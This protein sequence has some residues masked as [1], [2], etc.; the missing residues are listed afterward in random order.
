VVQVFDLRGLMFVFRIRFVMDI[1]DTKVILTCDM[2]MVSLILKL[3]LREI[4]GVT[5]IAD[6]LPTKN[7]LL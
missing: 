7:L 4:S 2:T 5:D 6:R 3:R 1:V